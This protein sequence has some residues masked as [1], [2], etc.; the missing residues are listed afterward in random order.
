VAPLGEE[1][2]EVMRRGC[3]EDRWVD[4]VPTEGKTGG[5]FSSGTRGTHPF[6]VMSYDGTT[7]SLGT[8]AH[9]LGHSMHSYLAWKTQP[10]VYA[11]YALFAAE[12][13]SNFHQVLLRAHLLETVSDRA[14]RLAVLDEA[15]PTS[16]ATSS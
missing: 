16:I 1:Y 13:A 5:A 9:E 6:I 2:V 10:Q 7:T 15:S 3:L 12:V 14:L 8:L 11:D 4:A